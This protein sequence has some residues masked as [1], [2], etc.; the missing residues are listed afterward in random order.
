[1]S[2]HYKLLKDLPTFKK[3]D[4][5]YLSDSGS[6]FL[7]DP[8]PPHYKSRVMAYHHTTLEKFPNILEDWFE[9]LEES[10]GSW[11]PELGGKYFHI[12]GSGEPF[13]NKWGDNSIDASYSAVGNVFRTKE[14]AEKALAWLKARKTLFDDAKGF[15]PNWG[16]G[17]ELKWYVCYDWETD[18]HGEGGGLYPEY[19]AQVAYIP[20]PYFTTEE[21]AKASI[22]NHEKEW[23][24]YLGVE[25]V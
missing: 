5:F 4:L 10:K 19:E 16:T 21:D 12:T 7:E 6:L 8:T 14:E 25:D 3:G 23:K 15:E 22:R 17:G 13:A 20:G 9:E 2:K 18:S 11:R 1:M 24:I